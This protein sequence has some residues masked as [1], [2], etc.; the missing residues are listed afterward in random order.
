[1]AQTAQ[2]ANNLMFEELCLL[3]EA[4]E[5]RRAKGAPKRR[6]VA[7]AAAKKKPRTARSR[8]RRR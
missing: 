4:I 8:A 7:K 2:L 3:T 6:S 1:M 5:R